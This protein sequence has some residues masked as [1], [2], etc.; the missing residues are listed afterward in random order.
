VGKNGTK[1][2]MATIE[3]VTFLG[4]KAMQMTYQVSFLCE[5]PY[6]PYQTKK[7]VGR[8]FQALNLV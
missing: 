2:D 1:K 5:A 8:E 3:G 6:W 4:A 7:N